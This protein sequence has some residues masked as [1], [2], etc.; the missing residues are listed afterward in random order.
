MHVFL[1]IPAYD[2]K[3]TTDLA[4][5]LVGL[6]FELSNRGDVFELQM[7]NNCSLVQKARNHLVKLFL[8]SD[9]DV[10]FFVDSDISFE[11]KDFLKI[12]KHT[13]K[14]QIVAG[15]Y[16]VKDDSRLVHLDYLIE[17]DRP[18]LTEEGLVYTRGVGG[19]FMCIRRGALQRMLDEYPELVYTSTDGAFAGMQMPCLFD[20][21][22]KDNK[23]YGEDVL[24]CRR[25]MAVGIDIL[26]DPT[27]RLKHHGTKAYSL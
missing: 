1:G 17:H 22:L 3:I 18:K 9:A 24:F 13:E 7:L 14:H 4:H 2:G 20:T 27:L 16:V 25:A 26:V 19:G 5:S 11:V 10:L 15:A 21:A 23:Y 8:D 12:L 6:A